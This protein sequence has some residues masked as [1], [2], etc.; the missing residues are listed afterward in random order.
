MT[1]R[2]GLPLNAIALS[3]R[4]PTRRDR[5]V[6]SFVQIDIAPSSLVYGAVVPT[7]TCLTEPDGRAYAIEVLIHASHPASAEDLYLR[8]KRVE[9]DRILRYHCP[10]LDDAQ[11]LKQNEPRETMDAI[12]WR[13]SLRDRLH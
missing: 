7:V 8:E 13:K 4:K 11:W 9:C 3:Y 1:S 5:V 12:G 2:R 6:L 10:S